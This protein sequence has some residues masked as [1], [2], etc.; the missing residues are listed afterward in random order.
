[1]PAHTIPAT[2]RRYTW[3]T[4]TRR[5]WQAFRLAL[6]VLPERCRDS[7]ADRIRRA[8]DDQN[9]RPLARRSRILRDARRR[10]TPRNAYGSPYITHTDTGWN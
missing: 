10:I 4:A 7:A 9:P 3:E 1:M 8:D 2:A 5:R 6:A